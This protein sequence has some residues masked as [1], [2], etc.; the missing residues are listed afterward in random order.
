MLHKGLLHTDCWMG[1][2]G[3]LLNN[4]FAKEISNKIAQNT[5]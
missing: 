3:Y 2:G 5:L 1:V 4:I